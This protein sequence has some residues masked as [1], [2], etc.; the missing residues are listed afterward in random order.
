L[1]PHKYSVLLSVEE[2]LCCAAHFAQKRRMDS[3]E[4]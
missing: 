3:K 2:G 4:R 1:P